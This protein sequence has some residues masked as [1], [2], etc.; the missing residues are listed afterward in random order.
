MDFSA[1]MCLMIILKVTK[2]QGFLSLEKIFFEKPQGKAGGGEGGSK[3]H[4]SRFRVKTMLVSI[5]VLGFKTTR[6]SLTL[7]QTL[8]KEKEKRLTHHV[9]STDNILLSKI[10]NNYIYVLIN[11]A[12]MRVSVSNRSS[13]NNEILFLID[14]ILNH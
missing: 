7:S 6:L 8:K 1:K 9:L 2:N 12:V 3:W 4:P 5:Q 10:S 11:V 14:C 13:N